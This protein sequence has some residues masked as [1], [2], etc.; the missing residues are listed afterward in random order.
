MDVQE[1]YSGLRAQDLQVCRHENAGILQCCD[2]ICCDFS[3]SERSAVSGDFRHVARASLH[4][5]SAAAKPR[6]E[7]KKKKNSSSGV[8]FLPLRS[9]FRGFYT[10]LGS[11]L[12]SYM[13]ERVAP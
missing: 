5:G 12:T 8:S 1:N 6:L 9:Q 10:N 7:Q 3:G 13:P 4:S 2:A 11:S